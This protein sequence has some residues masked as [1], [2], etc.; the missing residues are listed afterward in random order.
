M[1]KRPTSDTPALM[2][3]A[4][5]RAPGF[6]VPKGPDDGGKQAENAVVPEKATALK[7]ATAVPAPAKVSSGATAAK[8]KASVKR[9]DDTAEPATLDAVEPE[10][11]AVKD[12]TRGGKIPGH[13]AGRPALPPHAEGE[14]ASAG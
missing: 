13:L 11:K 6:T 14:H 2:Q 8:R 5:P 10:A 12:A 4:T 3:A 1:P 7:A 9:R